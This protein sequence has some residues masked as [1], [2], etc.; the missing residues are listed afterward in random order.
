MPTHWGFSSALGFYFHRN[1]AAET[2]PGLTQHRKGP[3][4]LS[5]GCTPHRVLSAFHSYLL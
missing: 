2:D 3:R 4:A 5:P 1:G